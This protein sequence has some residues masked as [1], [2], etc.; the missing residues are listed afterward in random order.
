M[1]LTM[2]R[3]PNS[4]MRIAYILVSVAVPPFGLLFCVLFGVVRYWGWPAAIAL[5]LF[6]TMLVLMIG[7]IWAFTSVEIGPG[8]VILRTPLKATSIQASN[9]KRVDLKPPVHTLSLGWSW[10][11]PQ[12]QCV[13]YRKT[14]DFNHTLRHQQNP[15]IVAKYAIGEQPIN[16]SAMPDGL[17][18]RIAQT[19]DPTHWPPLPE[20]EQG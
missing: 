19:L 12:S 10:W 18:R 5:T 6:G 11:N 13:I 20:P 2:I 7:S 14:V 8:L 4:P 9:V 15:H 3:Y 16:V 17:K 1:T